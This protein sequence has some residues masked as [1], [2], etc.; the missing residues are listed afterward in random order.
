MRKLEQISKQDKDEIL[1]LYRSFIG[2]EGCTWTQDYPDSSTFEMDTDSNNLFG[3][4]ENNKIIAVISIDQDDL[5]TKLDCWNSDIGRTA[6]ISR[7]AV[8]ADYQNQ[9]I[10]GEMIKQ[11]CLILE[12]R[13][14]RGVHYL[15][16]PYNKRALAAYSKLD[17]E[18]AGESD[19][20][21]HH[22]FC[23]EKNLTPGGTL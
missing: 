23:Y 10:A 4:R 14:F 7:L 9:G 20:Y 18:L 12:Q 13:G 19:L 17:F 6:E 8:A 15:V 22:W 3:I 11:L 16:Y 1:A 2:W 5:V 21:G